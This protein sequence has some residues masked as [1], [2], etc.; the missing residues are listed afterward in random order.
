MEDECLRNEESNCI[1]LLHL[2]KVSLFETNTAS[3]GQLYKIQCLGM[4]DMNFW[5]TL[6]FFS[7]GLVWVHLMH[8]TGEKSKHTTSLGY[9]HNKARLK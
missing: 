2:L 1:F 8:R 3:E 4:T 7:F 6:A 5:M 9:L